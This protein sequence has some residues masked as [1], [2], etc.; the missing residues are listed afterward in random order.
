[1]QTTAHA[2]RHFLRNGLVL[3]LPIASVLAFENHG[4]IADTASSLMG[5]MQLVCG[6]LLMGITWHFANGTAM[7]MI[8]G[9]AACAL[10][11]FL[12]SLA[13]LREPVSG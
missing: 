9:I 8:T 4:D 12:L 7:P 13:S 10:L 2:S 1:M 5:S 3:G 11:A 6:A